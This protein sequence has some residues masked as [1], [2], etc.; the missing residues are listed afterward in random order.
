MEW[1]ARHHCRE[2][3]RIRQAE[4]S[5]FTTLEQL[6]ILVTCSVPVGRAT[7]K[8]APV[9]SP[10]V[11]PAARPLVGRTAELDVLFGL[12]DRPGH[13]AGR[14]SGAKANAVLDAERNPALK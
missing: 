5:L 8:G 6:A 3:G 9:S 2:L 7:P 14:A 1:V 12:V 13:L 11:L 10:T 4:P